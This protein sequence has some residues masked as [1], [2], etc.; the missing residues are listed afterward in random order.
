MAW[1]NWLSIAL[2]VM[3]VFFIASMW[4]SFLKSK[5]SFLITVGTVLV[6]VAIILAIVP[7]PKSI[8][9]DTSGGDTLPQ[10]IITS[11]E[12]NTTVP[13]QITVT[14][15][16]TIAVPGYMHMYVVVESGSYWWPQVGE[17][18]VV[19]NDASGHYEFSVPVQVGVASDTGITFNIKVLLVDGVAD[20]YFHNWFAQ[21]TAV[22]GWD[23]N[24]IFGV[25]L[26]TNI[27][28]SAAI[29]VIRG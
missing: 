9:T 24:L 13:Q 3:G 15:Y 8:N 22:Q 5:Q 29:A 23:D 10:I 26:D 18:S 27:I 20:D 12:P 28:T 1:H 2:G 21:N 6:I 17:I 14:G 7:F 25:G 4:I 19:Y 16:T 11:P